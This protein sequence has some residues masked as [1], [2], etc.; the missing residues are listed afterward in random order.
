[1]KLRL[2]PYLLE[3]RRLGWHRALVPLYV[4][5]RFERIDSD[6]TGGKAREQKRP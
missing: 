6:I 2:A 5:A 1:M 3:V 4:G